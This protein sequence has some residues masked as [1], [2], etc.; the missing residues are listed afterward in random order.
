[1]RLVAGIDPGV[2]P[3]ISAWCP[4]AATKNKISGLPAT[5]REVVDAGGELKTGVMTVTSGRWVPPWYG[6]LTA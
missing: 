3:P 1:L 6:S 5:R 2:R 4:R